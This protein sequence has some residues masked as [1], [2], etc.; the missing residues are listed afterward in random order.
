MISLHQLYGTPGHSQDIYHALE[1]SVADHQETTAPT[2]VQSNTI[3][4]AHTP[5]AHTNITSAKPIET[6][7]STSTFFGTLF[8]KR[9]GVAART[10]NSVPQRTSRNVT[11]T[12]N[13]TPTPVT[14]ITT[15]GNNVT[16]SGNNVTS[17]GNIAGS[18]YTQG[19]T[20]TGPAPGGGTLTQNL[21]PLYFATNATAQ[22]VAKLLGGTVSSQAA[23]GPNNP[24]SASS[25]QEYVTING[26]QYNAGLLASELYHGDI[27]AATFSE[28][29]HS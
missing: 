28:Q 23:Y 19:V 1:P 15:S 20:E 22:Y 2:N 9:P 21:N 14:P 8:G 27:S 3:V 7:P 12:L 10:T 26:Q 4:S 11:P 5:T 18:A 29:G 6:P 24:V 16:S 17:F 25:S 13:A